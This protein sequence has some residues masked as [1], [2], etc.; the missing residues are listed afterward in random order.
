VE[1]E[2]IVPVK[3]TKKSKE[4]HS[5]NTKNNFSFLPYFYSIKRIE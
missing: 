5:K 3:P 1:K 4:K 2:V